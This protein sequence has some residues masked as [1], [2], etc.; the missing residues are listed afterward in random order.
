MRVFA[1]RQLLVVGRTGNRSVDV[2]ELAAALGFPLPDLRRLVAGGEIVF[3]WKFYLVSHEIMSFQV[4]A[5]SP[6]I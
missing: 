6:G 1:D 2:G 3:R 4:K 5:G